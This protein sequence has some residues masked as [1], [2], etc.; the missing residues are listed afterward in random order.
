MQPSPWG[1]LCLALSLAAC[2]PTPVPK[3]SPSPTVQPSPTPTPCVVPPD[4][5]AWT[6]VEGV[7]PQLVP[8]VRAAQEAVGDVCGTDPQ[9]SLD[10][11]A[12]ALRRAGYCAGRQTD[13][14][15]VQRGDRAW[16]EHHAVAYGNG[17]WIATP[18]RGTWTV[19][20]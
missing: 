20:P 8:A 1:W 12:S 5:A 11:L 13:A 4:S 16:E 7:A 19:R 15:M 17:C 6:P 9:T 14:V 18:Y 2:S 10:I 3:P